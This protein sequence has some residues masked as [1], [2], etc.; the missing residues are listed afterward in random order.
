MIFDLLGS[1]IIQLYDTTSYA[2]KS[3]GIW[4]HLTVMDISVS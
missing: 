2:I 1:A 3:H 4:S